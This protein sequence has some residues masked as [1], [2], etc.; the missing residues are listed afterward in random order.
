MERRLEMINTLLGRAEE[1]KT[2]ERETI[3]KACLT[4][5][6]ENAAAFGESSKTLMEAGKEKRPFTEKLTAEIT[7]AEEKLVQYDELDAL[8]KKAEELTEREQQLK[9]SGRLLS[10]RM[11]NL[12][13]R[14]QSS[15]K[16][17]QT[18]NDTE[19]KLLECAARLKA[20]EGEITSLKDLKQNADQAS[21][22]QKLCRTHRT[23]IWKFRGKVKH[24][25]R[26][27]IRWNVFF[28]TSRRAFSP[29]GFE[30]ARRVLCA[31][32]QSIR[33]RRKKCRRRRQRLS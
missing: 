8:R 27:T 22:W 11:K 2:R 20:L 10:E 16:E 6:W 32:R 14:I 4:G 15:E 33:V 7:A 31:A 26:N 17:A 18:L 21:E 5:A 3:R 1:R 30:K 19:T 25:V 12:T 29:R 28:W 24:F 13:E 23:N 9:E